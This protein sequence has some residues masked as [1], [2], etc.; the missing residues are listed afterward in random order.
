MNRLAELAATYAQLEAIAKAAMNLAIVIDDMT[1][2][3]PLVRACAFMREAMQA[4][5][6]RGSA[7]DESPEPTAP[8]VVN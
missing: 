7:L 5:R 3:F 1:V 6:D 8:V 4:E 2:A